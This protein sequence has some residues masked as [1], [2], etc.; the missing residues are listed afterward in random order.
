MN[1]RVI[2]V[3]GQ[4][5]AYYEN[6]RRED[7]PD[8]PAVIFVHGNSMSSRSYIRQMESPFL[9]KYRLIAIDLPGHGM[10]GPPVHPEKTYTFPGLGGIIAG[11]VE[12]LAIKD[13][14]FVGWSL[15]GNLLIEALDLL[16]SARG[17]MLV[18]SFLPSLPP[19]LAAAA[20]PH[21]VLGSLFKADLTD[22]EVN[23]WAEALMK[24]GVTPPPFVA[25]DIRKTDE[26]FRASMAKVIAQGLLQDEVAIAG[27]LKL[28][29]AFILGGGDQIL[30]ESYVRS[31]HIPSLWRNDLQI[32]PDAG[33]LLEWEQPDKFNRLLDDFI[34]EVSG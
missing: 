25:N 6:K 28:P 20:Y 33:H 34:R 2:D 7:S 31:L 8:L 26:R 18:S 5:L 10:S 15:G 23:I 1:P 4:R 29:V 17:L 13:A 9:N 14:V 22:E 32:I 30:R 12:K 24:S 19:D 27:H 3:A 11:F 21:P 16:P